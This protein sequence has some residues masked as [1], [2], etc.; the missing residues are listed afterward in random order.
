MSKLS[1]E[2]KEELEKYSYGKRNFML[3][4]IYFSLFVC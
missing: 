4:R 3:Y 2:T 1:G